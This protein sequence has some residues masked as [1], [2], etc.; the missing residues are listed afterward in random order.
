MVSRSAVKPIFLG[1]GTAAVMAAG[2][3]SAIAFESPSPSASTSPS[4]SAPADPAPVLSLVVTGGGP[5]TA[6]KA[7]AVTMKVATD[8]G[9]LTDV[10]ITAVKVTTSVRGVKTK[11]T[12]GC[13]PPATAPA[14]ILDKV[15]VKG[16]SLTSYV[17]VPDTLKQPVTV[18]IKVTATGKFGETEETD[19]DTASVGFRPVPKP[20]KPPTKPKPSP[21]LTPG[22][23]DGPSDGK[24]G[25]DNN[26]SSGGNSGS[27]SGGSSSGGSSSGGSTTGSGSGSGTTGGSVSSTP[28][29]TFTAQSPQV[30]LPPVAP[31]SPSVAPDPSVTTP[32]SRLRGNQSP[33]AQDLTFERMASTQVAWLAALLVA[34]S[35]LLTQLRLGRRYTAAAA[36][37]PKGTHRRTRRGMFGK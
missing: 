2:S 18:T 22:S 10:K 5:V 36:A 8:T 26:G 33:V 35:L 31:P 27:G 7:V 14:C 16:K 3:G 13:P 1:L 4:T 17:S 11:V 32:E 30:A 12:E 29:G 9:L 15:N 34:V 28:N 37:R 20:S 6:D 19:F 23:G 24:E 21:T 25:K